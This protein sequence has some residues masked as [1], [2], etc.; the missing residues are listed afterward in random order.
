MQTLFDQGE[1]EHPSSGKVA[2][3]DTL[4]GNPRFRVPPR[5]PVEMHRAS[6]DE[7]PEPDPPA[8]IIWALVCGLDL[9]G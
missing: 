9:G 2:A 1:T 5:N 8:R 7:L 6:L 3:V 4:G